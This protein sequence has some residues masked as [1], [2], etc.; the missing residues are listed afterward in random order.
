[1]GN[2]DSVNT[3]TYNVL[4]GKCRKNI[5]G[6][7]VEISGKREMHHSANQ[8]SIFSNGQIGSDPI[9]PMTFG[10]KMLNTFSFDCLQICQHVHVMLIKNRL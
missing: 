9:I 10:K 4:R 1:M 5:S 2:R 8:P 7:T 3:S 6:S